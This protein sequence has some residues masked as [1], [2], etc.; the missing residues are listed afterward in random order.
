MHSRSGKG[1]GSLWAKFK[2]G[3]EENTRAEVT[4]NCAIG[5]T[6]EV[7]RAIR[8]ALHRGKKRK[9]KLHIYKNLLRKEE[10]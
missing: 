5:K 1:W 6:D 9:Q 10:R 8:S 4:A 2:K 3:E 7:R